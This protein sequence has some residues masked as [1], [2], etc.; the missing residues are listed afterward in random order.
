MPQNLQT[1]S[2][3]SLIFLFSISFFHCQFLVSGTVADSLQK[4]PLSG[5]SIFINDNVSATLVSTGSFKISSDSI[6]YKLRFQ[7]KGFDL[8]TVNITQKSPV[9]LKVILSQDSVENIEGVVIQGTAIK[10]KNKKDNPA[11]AIMQRVWANKR[12]NGLDNYKS[13]QYKEYE[14]IQFN[15]SNIDSAFMKRKI[16]NK[17]DFIFKYADSAANGKLSLPMFLN[18]S[19]YNIYGENQPAKKEK[20][21]LVAQKTSGFQDNQIMA[22]TVKN[23]YKE[24]N[25]YDNTLNFFN[26]GFQSPV[27]TDGFS[28]Y[29]YNLIDT[30]SVRG[31]DCYHIKYFPRRTDVL[32]F[33]G[34]LYISKDAYA[35][36][37]VSLKSSKN[38]NVNFVNGV[39]TELEFDNP[40]EKTFIPLKNTTEFDL[41]LISKN[42]DSNGMLARRTVDYSDYEF[43]KE[44]N[45]T[46]FQNETP[47]TTQEITKTD[48]FWEQNRSD[49]LNVE[50][51]GVYKMLSQ[52]QQIPK[53]KRFIKIYET[54]SSGYFNVGHAFDIGDIYSVYGSN[55]IEGDRIRLGGKTYF[56]PNDDWRIQGYGAYGF[57][58]KQFKYGIEGKYMFN[59]TNRFQIGAGA[60]RDILQLGVALTGDDGIM[61]RSFASSTVF[62]SGDN[63]SLSS[64]TQES[65]YTSIEPIKN[66]QIRL[67]G[68]LR[69]IKSGNNELFDLTYNYGNEIRKTVNDSHFVLSLIA[70]PGAKFSETGIDR[71]SHTTLAPSFVLKYTRGVKGLFNADFNYNKLQFLYTQPILTGVW[72][73]SILN[74]EAGKTFETLPLALQNVIPGN[75]SY[76]L[77]PNTFALLNYYEFVAD[78]YTTLNIEHHF[79][80][81]ILSYIPLIK[82]LKLREV[83][84]FRAAYGTL[85]DASKGINRSAVQYSAPSD[86]V[87]YEYG[88][89]IENIGFGNLRIL[90]VDFNWRGNYLDRPNISK[91]GI[92][93]GFQ[94]NF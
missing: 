47:K 32:A 35:V 48:D 26:I 31:E 39:F 27:S 61:S 10:Y 4:K 45:P 5:V 3:Y 83:A 18:E 60:R 46:V 28:T 77:I 25:I 78:N 94:V 88:F 23:L 51:A 11:Y 57:K 64:S 29:D 13:Y 33:I 69:S 20:K 66:F 68:T 36:V 30:I 38:M 44:I 85:S 22:T 59:K 82:K 93:A 34:D 7:K 50:E 49:S 40:D 92:K 12:K 52:L 6:I 56:S 65:I 37:K 75:Q 42:K 81:K 54:A 58:D 24:I 73:K 21:D 14:K 76:S 9:V 89:G 8:K 55:V 72:G 19:V 86:H 67:D 91:F 62:A 87:Y 16:F 84:L 1:K 79:N 90:R 41:S 71:Y 17:V 43:N 15:L 80:G 74:F 63:T 53:F 2:L 70:N